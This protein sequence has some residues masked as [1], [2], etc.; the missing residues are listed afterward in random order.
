L[1]AAK[2]ADTLLMV[3]LPDSIRPAGGPSEP[4]DA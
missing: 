1:M 3:G 4:F 2:I